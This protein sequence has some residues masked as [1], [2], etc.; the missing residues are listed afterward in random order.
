MGFRTKNACMVILYAHAPELRLQTSA[1][2][3][4]GSGQKGK[5]QMTSI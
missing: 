2:N 5:I 4:N 1:S 3:Y